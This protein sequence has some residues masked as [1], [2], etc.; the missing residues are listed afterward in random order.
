MTAADDTA[1]RRARL[2]LMLAAE[3]GNARLLELVE[4][5]GA[6]SVEGRLRSGHLY[7]P[8]LAPVAERLAAG[9]DTEL[10]AGWPP[11]QVRDWCVRATASGRRRS[12]CSAR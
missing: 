1:E 9:L 8:G 10:R 7:G 12:T 3:P 4:E 2:S 5:D 6:A 11:P